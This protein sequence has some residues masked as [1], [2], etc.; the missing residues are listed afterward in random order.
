MTR[1]YSPERPYRVQETAALSPHDFFVGLFAAL[2]KAGIQDLRCTH[3][4]VATLQEHSPEDVKTLVG[5]LGFDPLMGSCETLE[6]VFY[7]LLA[8][9]G[10]ELEY[11]GAG[12]RR[13][14]QPVLVQVYE[15]RVRPATPTDELRALHARVADNF[16]RIARGLE[17]VYAVPVKE[18][19][20]HP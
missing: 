14:I 20:E 5:F 2:H 16:V 9:G 13:S 1:L 10:I 8:W 3:R 18:D 7:E 17:P 15:Q 19:H 6:A 12:T 4:W 11:F